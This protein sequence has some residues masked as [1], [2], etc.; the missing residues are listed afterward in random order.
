MVGDRVDREVAP[1]E[2]VS[3]RDAELHY[4]VPAVGADVPAERGDLVGP[5]V[6]VEYRHRAVLDPHR[7][8]T[9]E[10]APHVLRRRRRGEIEVVVLESEQIVADRAAHAPGF[11][12]GILQRLCDAQHFGRDGQTVGEIHRTRKS[13]RGTRDGRGGSG[14]AASQTMIYPLTRYP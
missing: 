7:H 8:R 13:E 3:E 6:P 4:G 1:G 9:L 14:H 2:V 10:Q 5:L 11:E 12:A